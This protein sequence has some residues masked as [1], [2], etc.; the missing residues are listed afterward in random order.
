MVLPTMGQGPLFEL[1]YFPSRT[2]KHIKVIRTYTVDALTGARKLVR[3][4]PYDRHGYSA[5]TA[6]R[7]VY[8]AQGRLVLQETYQWVS[9]TAKPIPRREMSSRYSIEYTA[10][11]IVQHVKNESFGKYHEGVSEY[12][13]YSHKVHPCFGLTECV[14]VINWGQEYIDT[15]RYLCE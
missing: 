3:T 14:Y 13:L 5:D 15:L 4:E 12:Q 10:D 1:P 2:T 11:G 7:N 8:D 6:Y 9:S